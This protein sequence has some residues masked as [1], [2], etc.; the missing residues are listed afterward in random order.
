MYEKITTAALFCLV[1][2]GLAAG[3][4][5]PNTPE[6]LFADGVSQ[7]ER[8]RFNLAVRSFERLAERFP[9]SALVGQAR[10]LAG[11]ALAYDRNKPRPEQALAAFRALE[12]SDPA[13]ASRAALAAANC[14]AHNYMR[15]H[16]EDRGP[17]PDFSA[18]R[19]AYEHVM[20]TYPESAEAHQAAYYLARS[21]EMDTF[22]PDYKEAARRYKAILAEL[23]GSVWASR[24]CHRLAR[25]YDDLDPD[26]EQAIRYY[27]QHIPTRDPDDQ[28]RILRCMFRI[29]ALYMDELGDQKSAREWFERMQ[30]DYPRSVWS[31]RVL[32]RLDKLDELEGSEKTPDE[33]NHWKTD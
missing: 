26:P 4:G 23:P 16:Y 15:V 32:N 24:A 19:K 8:G 33:R 10:L 21:Y 3:C 17:L 29:A 31:N 9:E 18:A 7:I 25:I 27:K 12:K 20:A 30:R 14:L 11:L 28:E 6:D 5:G 2:A 13:M 22:E 1:A